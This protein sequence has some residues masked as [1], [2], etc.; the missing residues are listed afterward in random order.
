MSHFLNASQLAE[1]AEAQG[2]DEIVTMLEKAAQTAAIAIAGKRKDI[3]IVDDASLQSGFGGLCVG[4]GPKRKGQKCPDD[5]RD[6]DNG[7]TW[8]EGLGE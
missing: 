1:E 2:L 4:F 8:A 6:Y 3:K 5:F 7:S